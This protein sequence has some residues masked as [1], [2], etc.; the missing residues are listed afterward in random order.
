MSCCPRTK[1]AVRIVRGAVNAAVG[2]NEEM[3]KERL[4]IC[5]NC[6]HL[7]RGPQCYICGCFLDLKTRVPEE[8][9]PLNK[10]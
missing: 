10:W 5:K 1:K 4:L 3:S 8:T 9:C 6:V 7:R 2:A